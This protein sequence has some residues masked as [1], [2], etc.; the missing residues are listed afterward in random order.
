M[1]KM[2]FSLILVLMF[3]CFVYADNKLY[4]SPYDDCEQVWVDNIIKASSYVYISCFGIS[5][6][7]ICQTLVDRS[8]AGIR[9]LICTDRLQSGHKKSK[10]WRK[11]LESVGVEYVVKRTGVFEHNKMAVIDDNIVIIGSWNLSGSAQSQD[12]SIVVITG[13]QIDAR[14]VKYAIERIYRRDK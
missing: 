11:R 14:Q 5:N 9:I 13:N 7:R 4:F 8:S 12:N 6:D 10:E 1:K 2:L 3:Q